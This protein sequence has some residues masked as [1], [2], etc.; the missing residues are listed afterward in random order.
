MQARQTSSTNSSCSVVIGMKNGFS[1]AVS[2]AAA[3]PDAL[4]AR[5][6]ARFISRSATG[7]DSRLPRIRPAVAAAMPSS[8]APCRLRVSP[9]LAA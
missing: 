4:D 3:W 1:G 2:G 9:K 7:P 8:I 5:A 6:L